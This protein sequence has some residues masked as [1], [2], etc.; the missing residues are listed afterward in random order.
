MQSAEAVKMPDVL[1]TFHATAI[2]PVGAGPSEYGKVIEHE[3]E[4]MARAGK[5]ADLKAD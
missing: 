5:V 2:D 1:K 3:N 4:V